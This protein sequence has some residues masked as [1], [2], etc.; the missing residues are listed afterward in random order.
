MDVLHILAAVVHHHPAVGQD[1]EGAGLP[2]KGG[3]LQGVHQVGV[4]VGNG[5]GLIVKAAVAALPGGNG[6]HHDLRLVRDHG[7]CHD[8]LVF[9]NQ[10]GKLAPQVQIAPVPGQGEVFAVPGDEV[11]VCEVAFLTG[12]IHIGHDLGVAVRFFQI[13]LPH[14]HPAPVD[15]DQIMQRL[16]GLVE[17]LRQVGD[18]LFVNRLGDKAEVGKAGPDHPRGQRKGQQECGQSFFH[19]TALLSK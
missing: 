15:G 2:V 11:E 5:N 7:V 6:K 18:A 14:P 16:V 3:D 17:N 1:R 9:Q 4:V 8:G 10:L 13:G 19:G 12:L